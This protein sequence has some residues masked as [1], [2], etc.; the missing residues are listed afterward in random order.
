MI[1]GQCFNDR[2]HAFIVLHRLARLEE[3]NRLIARH[4]NIITA[5][6]E[7][8]DRDGERFS[9]STLRAEVFREAL[10]NMREKITGTKRQR[11]QWET[12][13]SCDQPLEFT[14]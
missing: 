10:V 4:G 7:L 1:P 8:E 6:K 9:F 5:T 11:E 12:T 14:P 13:C 3:Y 2:E